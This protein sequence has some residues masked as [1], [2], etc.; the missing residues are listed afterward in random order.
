[1]QEPKF[2]TSGRPRLDKDRRGVSLEVVVLNIMG[3]GALDPT[4]ACFSTSF[5]AFSIKR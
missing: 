3:L 4:F 5:I 1:M 2:K